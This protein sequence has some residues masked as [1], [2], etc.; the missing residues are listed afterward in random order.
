M[1]NQTTEKTITS[2]ATSFDILDDVT[3]RLIHILPPLTT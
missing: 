3:G 1:N 2:T